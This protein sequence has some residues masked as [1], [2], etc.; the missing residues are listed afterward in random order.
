LAV[1]ASSR[2]FHLRVHLPGLKIRVIDVVDLM[3]LRPKSEH[4]RGLSDIHL[5]CVFT[6]DRHI[7]FGFHGCPWLVH[8]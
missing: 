4:P 7:V 8:G 3:N 5:R 6:K 1:H 2:R